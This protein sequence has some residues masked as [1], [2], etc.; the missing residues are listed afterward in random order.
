MPSAGPHAG[1]A[2]VSAVDQSFSGS[3]SEY[4]GVGIDPKMRSYVSSSARHHEA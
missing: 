2:R 4:D 1:S 3:S